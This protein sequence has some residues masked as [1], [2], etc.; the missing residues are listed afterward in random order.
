MFKS[1]ALAVTIA[2]TP[3]L[4]QDS[5]IQTMPMIGECVPTEWLEGYIQGEFAEEGFAQGTSLFKLD[6]QTE[7]LAQMKLFVNYA[8]QTFSIVF[9]FAEDNISCLIATGNDFT[10]YITGDDI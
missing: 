10:P 7:A 4:A 1:L 3:A 6:A 2:A 5:L 9:E 8:A